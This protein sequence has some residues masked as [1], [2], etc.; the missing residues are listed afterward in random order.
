MEKV[1]K[2]QIIQLLQFCHKP[3]NSLLWLCKGYHLISNIRKKNGDLLPLDE[4][5]EGEK[6]HE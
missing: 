5:E 2:T 4:L 1:T 6:N 3:T